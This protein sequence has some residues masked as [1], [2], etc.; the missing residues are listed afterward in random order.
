MQCEFVENKTV[1]QAGPKV[2]EEERVEKILYIE[3]DVYLKIY[4]TI[5]NFIACIKIIF[6]F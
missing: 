4:Y 3:E 5:K 1:S 2:Y 6:N